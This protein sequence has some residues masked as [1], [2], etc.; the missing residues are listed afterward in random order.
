M[1]ETLDLTPPTSINAKTIKQRHRENLLT[2]GRENNGIV[3]GYVFSQ[4]VR[5]ALCEIHPDLAEYPHWVRVSVYNDF[6]RTFKKSLQDTYG[7]KCM[8]K[9]HLRKSFGSL[10][11][12]MIEIVG[13]KFFM[14][15]KLTNNIVAL[16]GCAD[17]NHYENENPNRRKARHIGNLIKEEGEKRAELP[18][19]EQMTLLESDISELSSDGVTV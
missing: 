9:R 5:A 16:Q 1:M 3:P 13:D 15:P 7:F 8:S 6:Y 19:D 17:M 18:A 14:F 2:Y 11:D 4:E 12:K 10:V